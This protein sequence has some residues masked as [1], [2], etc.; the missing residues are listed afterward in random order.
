MHGM[1]HQR[2]LNI[3]QTVRQPRNNHELNLRPSAASPPA[4]RID[5][6]LPF[7]NYGKRKLRP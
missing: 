3:F 7:A 1:R 4:L 6:I 2:K 5:G